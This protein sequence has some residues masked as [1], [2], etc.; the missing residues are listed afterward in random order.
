MFLVELL[1]RFLTSSNLRKNNS[2]VL[3]RLKRGAS[4]RSTERF[5]VLPIEI[6]DKSVEHTTRALHGLRG[7]RLNVQTELYTT[8]ALHGV[9]RTAARS[10][11]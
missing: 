2:W 11:H 1:G 9:I 4:D 7:D 3:G 6:A 5:W 10:H 8:R